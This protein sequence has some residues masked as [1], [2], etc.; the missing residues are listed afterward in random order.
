MTARQNDPE[1]IR[2]EGVNVLLAQL[3][4]DRGFSARAERRSRRGAPDVRVDLRSGDQVLLECKWEG[5]NALLESQ[6]EERLATFTEPL[7]VIGVLYPDRL[8]H[9]ENTQAVLEA[10]TDL[11]W[12]LHGS[13]GAKTN[14]RHVRSGSVAELADQSA[15]SSIGTGRRRPGDRCRQVRLGTRWNRRPSKSQGTPEYPAA[16]LIS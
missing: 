2:E 5:N 11:R 8:R 6:L 9:A 3:L 13:R 1:T 15:H 16:S 4:R 10:A 7:G 12:W 14:D